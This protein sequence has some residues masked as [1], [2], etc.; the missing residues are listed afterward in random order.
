MNYYFNYTSLAEIHGAVI[1]MRKKVS[2]DYGVKYIL[3]IS[4]K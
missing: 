1:D 4:M 3:E 2:Q